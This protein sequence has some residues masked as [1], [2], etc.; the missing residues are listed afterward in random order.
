MLYCSTNLYNLPG[1]GHHL[2]HTQ[3]LGASSAS[4]E[5]A[6]QKPKYSQPVQTPQNEL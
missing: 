4:E 5:V 3:S 1:T 2:N 6:V